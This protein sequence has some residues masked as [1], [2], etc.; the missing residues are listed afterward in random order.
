MEQA[1]FFADLADGPEGGRAWWSVTEDGVRIRC[2]AWPTGRSGTILLF[3][4]RTE[5]VEKYGR[6][7]SEFGGRGYTVLAV[8][9]RGQGLSDRPLADLLTGHVHEFVDYQKDVRALA[10]LAD[11]LDLPRPRF[12][13]AHSMGG[14]IGLRALHRRLD[15]SAAAFSAP[16]WGISMPAALRPVAWSLSWAGRSLGFGH[17]Y[18]PG[19]GADSYVGTA[20]FEENLLTTDDAM[21]AYMMRQLSGHPELALGGPSLHWLIEALTETRALR[22]MAPPALPVHC[23]V[24]GAERIVDTESIRQLMKRWPQGRLDVIDGAR[25]EVM[26]ERPE[27]RQRFF[28]AATGLFDRHRCAAPA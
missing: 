17:R 5:Y 3:P 10:G 7:A 28:E 15:V 14:A 25:H 9:W 18:A 11:K 19:T 27:I 26:M 4:G 8:D 21:Y 13:V 24:G 1:P 16:M 20:P 22:R 2:A 6:A 12:L 23:A